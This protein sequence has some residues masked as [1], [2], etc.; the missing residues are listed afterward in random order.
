MLADILA[1][2]KEERQGEKEEER[3]EEGSMEK[4]KEDWVALFEE[5]LKADAI[6]LRD[7]MRPTFTTM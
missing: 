7:K 3:Q 5:C 1:E 2:M 6:F 4:L